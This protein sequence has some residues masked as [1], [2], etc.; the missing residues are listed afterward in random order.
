LLFNGDGHVYQGLQWDYIRILDEIKQK[1][2]AIEKLTDP[3]NSTSYAY[4]LVYGKI[5]NYGILRDTLK[6]RQS[7]RKA[8]VSCNM[9]DYPMIEYMQF[10]LGV[11]Y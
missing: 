7:L 10:I 11:E 2:P 3:A 8:F 4:F 9:G 1:Y 6:N 5:V